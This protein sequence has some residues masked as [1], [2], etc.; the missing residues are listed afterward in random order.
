[1]VAAGEALVDVADAAVGG[2]AMR[3]QVPVSRRTA[4]VVV[5]RDGTID[6]AV[7]LTLSDAS[8]TALHLADGY[9]GT[10][11]VDGG[12]W[13][14]EVWVGGRP[15]ALHTGSTLPQLLAGVREVWGR[16]T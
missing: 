2:A 9:G 15:V 7:A 16:S 13:M 12:L 4:G 11:W 10:V 6:F 3:S 5:D 8:T 1:M 14:E